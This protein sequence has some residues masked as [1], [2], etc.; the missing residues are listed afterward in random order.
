MRNFFR[1]HRPGQ[2]GPELPDVSESM[3]LHESPQ[4][5]SAKDKGSA[6]PDKPYECPRDPAADTTVSEL[7]EL[8]ARDLC[9]REGIPVFWPRR[10]RDKRA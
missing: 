10:D 1:R 3:P 4:S 9:A 6:R 2:A 5:R 8:E 7:S